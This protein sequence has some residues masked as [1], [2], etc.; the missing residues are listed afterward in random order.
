[1]RAP[2]L[3]WVLGG[4]ALLLVIAL[5]IFLW[6]HDLKL[7]LG[8]DAADGL[9]VQAP[10]ALI[11]ASEPVPVSEAASQ[12]PQPPVEA[13]STQAQPV[14]ALASEAAPA[15]AVAAGGD[16][17]LEIRASQGGASWV[18]VVDG[19]GNNLASRL[20][21]S[22]E[23]LSLQVKAPVR[24]ILGNAPA[25]S[26]SWRGQPQPLQGYEQVRVAKLHLK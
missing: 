8:S 22:G 4:A 11:A 9:P 5:G 14:L 25:L 18:S 12:V 24:L 20:L 19:S 21:Q 2:G 13:S 6:P 17:V 7:A 3:R 16:A 26:L 1:L 23:L 10:A 15:V